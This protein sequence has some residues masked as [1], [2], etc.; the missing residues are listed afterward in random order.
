MKR[1]LFF[2]MIL[3]VL[4]ASLI[5]LPSCKKDCNG[6]GTLSLKNA[7]LNTVQKI[8]VDG[9]NYGT[10]DP[11]EHKDI[12]L[13]AGEHEFQFVGISGGNGC[14]PAKVIIVECKKTGF[15]CAN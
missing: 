15:Q 14:C 8:M 9:V 11:G 10:L 3:I 1:R 4:S 7:S 5:V 12:S 6:N 2:S 13:A